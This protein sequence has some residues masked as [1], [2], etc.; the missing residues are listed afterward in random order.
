M[1]RAH[2]DRVLLGLV[3]VAIVP[4]FAADLVLATD[5][6]QH[7]AQA[8]L[9]QRGTQTPFVVDLT[10]RPYLLATH[11]LLA[12]APIGGLELAGRLVL[13]IYA[14]SLIWALRAVVDS[15]PARDPR[16]VWL[17]P[18]FIQSWPVAYG[19]LP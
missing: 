17:A 7:L 5:L 15:S 19:F 6:P 2:R 18:L 10:P 8:A 4:F 9:A 12:L 14:V 1:T 3:L 13:L 16:R 11:L